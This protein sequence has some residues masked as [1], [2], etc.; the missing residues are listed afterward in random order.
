ME[1]DTGGLC[2]PKVGNQKTPVFQHRDSGLLG[3]YHPQA[4]S[5]PVQMQGR[6]SANEAAP[7]AINH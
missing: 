5:Q 1:V 3:T 4:P 6:A 7:E 2:Q